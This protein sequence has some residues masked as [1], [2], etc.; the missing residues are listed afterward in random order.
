MLTLICAS[1]AERVSDCQ[2]SCQCKLCVRN[3]RMCSYRF[4]FDF[5]AMR[6]RT[7]KVVEN[8]VARKTPSGG[9]K[10]ATMISCEKLNFI[11]PGTSAGGCKWSCRQ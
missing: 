7:S 2:W 4:A 3:N 1:T 6:L 9:S 5:L 10:I 8:P 11:M